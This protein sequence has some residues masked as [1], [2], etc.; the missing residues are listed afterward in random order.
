MLFRWG[1]KL[2]NL[3]KASYDLFSHTCLHTEMSFNAECFNCYDT[4]AFIKAN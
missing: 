4:S 1:A 2:L 3:L